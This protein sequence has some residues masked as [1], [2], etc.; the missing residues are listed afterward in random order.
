[1]LSN[2]TMTRKE[3]AKNIHNMREYKRKVTSSKEAAI[4]ALKKSG[5][6]TETGEVASPYKH[7]LGSNS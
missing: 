7:L 3:T 5:I 1:M 6:F 2:I 4:Q